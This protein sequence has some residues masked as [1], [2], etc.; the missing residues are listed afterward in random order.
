MVY[1]DSI[2]IFFGQTQFIYIKKIFF[3]EFGAWANWCLF[4]SGR[5]G[6]SEGTHGT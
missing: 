3:G 2:L 5:A 4:V 1:L 6:A